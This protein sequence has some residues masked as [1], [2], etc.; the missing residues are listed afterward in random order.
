MIYIFSLSPAAFALR[1]LKGRSSV[2]PVAQRGQ[3]ACERA[4]AARGRAPC[5]PARWDTRTVI[6][7]TTI[8]K[9]PEF[10]KPAINQLV[11]R[12]EWQSNKPYQKYDGDRLAGIT[13]D[14]TAALEAMRSI[15][16]EGNPAMMAG[17]NFVELQNC[18]KTEKQK[19]Q[20]KAPQ[21]ELQGLISTN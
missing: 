16:L 17:E 12:A 20:K 13:P 14:Q 7:S 15:G 9:P 1:I 21:P 4:S 2:N 18:R 11:S 10:L 6:A 8:A 3:G 5:R 19:E